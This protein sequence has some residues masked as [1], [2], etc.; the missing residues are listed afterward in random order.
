MVRE[1]SQID[2]NE[3]LKNRIKD[4]SEERTKQMSFK[5]IRRL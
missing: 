3:L 5:P 2:L 4:K 1:V